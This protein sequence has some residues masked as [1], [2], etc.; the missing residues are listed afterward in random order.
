MVIPIHKQGSRNIA[1]NYRPISL[2]N[3]LAKIFE[4][5]LKTRLTEHLEK[6]KILSSKQYGFRKKLNTELAIQKLTST[7]LKNFNDNKKIL[8]IFLDLQKAFDTVSHEKL[9]S[10]LSEVGVR[11]THLNLFKNYL[12]NRTQIVKVNNTMSSEKIITTGVPQGTVLGPVLFLVYMNNLLTNNAN[13]DLIS[14][15]DDTVITCSGD[16]W[17]DTY[18]TAE[19][20]IDSIKRCLDFNL[21]SLNSAKTKYIAFAPTRAGLPTAPRDIKIKNYVGTISIAESI[22]YLGVVF[23]QHMTWQKHIGYVNKRIR[24]TVHKFFILRNILT[25]KN[26]F[27]VYTSLIESILRYG[28]TSWGLLYKT[29]L[30]PLQTTQNYILKTILN[31]DMRYSTELI[32]NNNS[33]LDIRGLCILSILMY[34]QKNKQIEPIQHN[35]E[36]R[37]KNRKDLMLPKLNKGISQRCVDYI[38]VKLYNKLPPEIR[39]INKFKKY[40]I[41]VK[42]FILKEIKMLKTILD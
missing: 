25:R 40:K 21:L 10:K 4:H 9:L 29:S 36:T 12:E 27:I 35:H 37:A 38:G 6:N 33:I 3:N 5:C 14:F 28:I 8:A 39:D 19:H 7:I 23:D 22:K 11:G 13:Y 42:S 1:N 24:K 2:I 20:S 16:T 30:Q 18:Q 41:Q 34:I 15:A 26:M 31:K 17:E 32:Y